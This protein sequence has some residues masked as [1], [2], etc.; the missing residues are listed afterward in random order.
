M[1]TRELRQVSVL[2]CDLVGFTTLSESRDPEE[3]RELLSGYFDL[4]RSVISRYGG[5]VEKFI[6]DA[7]MAVWGAPVAREDDAERA[8]RAAL[9][10]LSAISAYGDERGTSLGARVGVATGS[11]ATTTPEEG[12][13]IGDRVN[14]AARIQ[15]VA[16]ARSCLVDDA[17]KNASSA[18]IVYRDAGTH[19]LK[20][21]SKSVHLNEAMRVIA[22]VGGAL[23]SQG[24]EAPFV[25]RDGELRLVKELFHTIVEQQRAHLVSIVGVAGIG[26]SRLAWEYFKYVD[27]LSQLFL[28]HRGRCLA[29]GDGV[30]YWALA[31]MVRSRAGIVEAED[32]TSAAEKLDA[33][34]A[35]YVPEPDEARWVQA[36]L[37]QLLAIDTSTSFDRED[38][39]AGWR[40][41]FERM[42]DNHAVIL[43]FEDMQWAD[44]ALLD[45]IEY[46]L[47][48]SRNHPI[49]VLTLTRPE[50]LER[51]SNWGAA[52]RNF[53]SISLEPLS[54][55]AMRDLISGLVPGL[56]SETRERILERSE[57]IPLY[58]VETIRMLIDRGLLVADEGSYRPVGPIEA[59]DIPETLQALIAARL[60]GLTDTERRLIQ[61]AAVLG[62]TFTKEGVAHLTG[63]TA[64]ALVE[65]LDALIRKELIAVQSDPR[66]PERGHYSFI[67]DMVR[68]VAYESLPKRDRKDKHIAAAAYLDSAFG[69]DDVEVVEILASHFRAA[70]ELAP[71]AD[72]AETVKSRA[73]ELTVRSGER[74]AALSDAVGARRYFEQAIAL[75]DDDLEQA[76]LEERAGQMA[77]AASQRSAGRAHFD[78]ATSLFDLVG[79]THASA[80]VA[81]RH[82]ELDFEDLQ[83]TQGIERMEKAFTLLSEDEPDA[84]LVTLAAQLGRLHLFSGALDIAHQRIEFAL[85]YA[86]KLNLREQ[87]VQAL[88][89]KSVIFDFNRRDEEAM[90][91]IRHALTVALEEGL[92][93]AALRAY[94]NYIAFLGGYDKFQEIVAVNAEALELARRIGNRYY[95][96]MFLSSEILN[97]VDLGEWDRVPEVCSQLRDATEISGFLKGRMLSAVYVF[98]GRGDLASA[99]DLLEFAS[100]LEHAEDTQ[101]RPMFLD[102]KALLLRA[103]GKFTEALE[104][105]NESVAAA[106]LFG[107]NE[108]RALIV[109]LFDVAYDADRARAE[110]VVREIEALSPGDTSRSLQ[111]FARRFRAKLS[112]NPRDEDFEFAI[113]TFRELGMRFHLGVTLL[114]YAEA[115]SDRGRPERATAHFHEAREIFEKLRATPWFERVER[116]SALASQG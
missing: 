73:R 76:K 81:A 55:T 64:D 46:L 45:F 19:E 26:K 49:F 101:M 90:L 30:T 1:P 94:N 53:T 32:A 106:N 31:E 91:L 66:S 21:K 25:G 36:R 105:A 41:F 85:K 92:S 18:A 12:M 57:G 34:V 39:F 100:E 37:A 4:S 69:V 95:E 103:E 16:R 10:L 62:K 65:A 87:F 24:L 60:D 68:K 27:G 54:P 17:T 112:S 99:K 50:L 83:I 86:E 109:D 22:M 97:S 3:V 59:L 89:T 102:A 8:V 110:E 52:H 23:K 35:Q 48:W 72:D 58:A 33:V 104:A 70:F 13:V 14:T 47:D 93:Q 98:V 2:F 56:P 61:E 84:D 88:N 40:L 42:A 51:R 63:I 111:A 29:Y 67:Q 77:A 38:L 71:T 43:S 80:R 28:G 7:V 107:K 78:R 9:E 5:T 108:Y 20:G 6:G 74:A 79:D 44:S 116:S 15:S 113:N 115:L 75:T 96:A 114:E 11:A 82:G